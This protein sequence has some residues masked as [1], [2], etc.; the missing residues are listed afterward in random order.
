MDA[1][2][3]I[4]LENQLAHSFVKIEFIKLDGTYRVLVCTKSYNQIPV[5]Q[6]PKR[7]TKPNDAVLKV[8]DWESKGWKSIRKDRIRQW[9]LYQ[10]PA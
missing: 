6:Q 1:L 5:E 9:E 8:F 2:D 10:N 3:L 4:R 7:P